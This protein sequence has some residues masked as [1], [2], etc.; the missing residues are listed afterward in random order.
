MDISHI[1]STHGNFT[2][3]AGSRHHTLLNSNETPL[4][5]DLLLIKS[6]SRQIDAR[7]LAIDD[8][9]ALLGQFER[10]T[11]ERQKSEWTGERSDG[12]TEWTQQAP[13]VLLELGGPL[14][15]NEQLDTDHPLAK[16]TDERQ[17][18]VRLRSQNNA[19]LSSLRRIP[20]EILDE[21]F[22]LTR[23]TIRSHFQRRRSTGSLNDSPW[24]LTH[25]SRSW[26]ATAISTS[27]LWS[28]VAISFTTSDLGPAGLYPLPMLEAQIGRAHNLK[29]H[30]Y[31]EQECDPRPQ[32]EVF[33]LLVSHSLRWEELS[34]GLT[35]ALVPLLEGLQDR[36]PLL[37]RL[38]LQWSSPE[39][40]AGVHSI[41]CFNRAPS[42]VDVTV[43]NE[44]RLVPLRLAFPQLLR[45]QLDGPWKLH[46]DILRVGSNLVEVRMILDF[47]FEATEP[48]SDS[49]IHLPYLRRLFVSHAVLLHFLVA[50][51]LDE[52]ALL[53]SYGDG[54]QSNFRPFVERSGCTVRRLCLY[55]RVEAAS[56]ADILKSTTTVTELVLVEAA[57][58]GGADSALLPVLTLAP[59]RPP[60]APQLQ[61]IC[62][63][64][65]EGNFL[66][67]NV[68][69]HMIS[70]RWKQPHRALRAATLLSADP[71]SP[72]D[73]LN[74]RQEGLDLLILDG[75]RAEEIMGD[76]TYQT[77]WN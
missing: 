63:G 65:A 22:T 4:D 3:A 13:A 77:S 16:L 24:I 12:E 20:P 39:S 62:L 61:S 28:V 19:V 46:R 9:I 68:C 59:E 55:G 41:D 6:M 30:F 64:S 73:D 18:L 50:P 72:V 75:R 60:L 21:I 42:L 40:D 53:T 71:L 5:S 56:L 10:P 48:W 49:A 38:H 31:G 25:V 17:S 2:P 51:A 67:L 58:L 74:M 8:E 33:K 69:M 70:S 34:I 37:R 14:E 23:P 15:D 43:V 54:I 1:A 44:Q 76:W 11:D 26:R 52:I 35:S 29:I 47:D 66:N 45:Y 57:E 36:I 32:T 7:I 27:S